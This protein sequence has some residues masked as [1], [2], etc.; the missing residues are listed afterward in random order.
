[1]LMTNKMAS[2]ILLLALFVSFLAISGCT[3]QD[4]AGKDK[5]A[6]I[7][8]AVA[9]Q[10][11]DGI[12]SA[13]SYKIVNLKKG[14]IIFGML[15]GQSVFY[16]DEATIK[17][18]KGSYKTL[19]S[20]M[21]VRPHPVYG[22]RTKL[23]TYEV[24]SDMDVPAGKCLANKTVTID[25]KTEILGDGGGFQYVVFDFSDRLKLLEESNLHE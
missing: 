21:Q 6:L 5:Q 25:G 2:V 18:G 4:I 22:Y 12:Y 11:E 8:A 23:G 15:P 1:M 7:S 3:A 9:Y 10:T 14:D 13:D 20:L 17:A 19:Y 24:L 16:T